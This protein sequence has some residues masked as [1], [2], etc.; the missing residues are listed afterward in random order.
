MN[1]LYSML[2]SQQYAQPEQ[3]QQPFAFMNPF[4]KA[5]YVMRTLRDPASFVKQQFPDIP[6]DIANDPNQILQYLQ[7]TRN[8]SNEQISQLVNQLS[9]W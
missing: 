7:R 4:Q 3:S 1:P 6:S 5:N 2:M 8:I 9:R